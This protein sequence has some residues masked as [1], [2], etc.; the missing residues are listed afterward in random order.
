[1]SASI[2]NPR[3]PSAIHRKLHAVRL[4][5]ATLTV[6]AAVAL[7]GC[8][9]ITLM[10][11]SMAVDWLFPF[12]G[13]FLRVFLVAFTGLA[14]VGGAIGFGLKPLRSAL[15]WNDAAGAVDRAI[16]QLQ[17]RWSTVA[18]L[19]SHR[20]WTKTPL[21]R[22][23]ADQV[24]SEAIAMETVV[25]LSRITPPIAV[26]PPLLALATSGL[27]LAAL[28]AAAP[29]HLSVLLKRFWNPTCTVT[30]TTLI[31]ETGDRM[32]P[33][34]ESID[35]V[36][37]T[38][39]VFRN[40][41]TL[42]V[43]DPT[44]DVRRVALRRS[45]Q[46]PDAFEHRMKVDE[47]LRYRVRA[48][49]GQTAW[50]RLD[51][52]DYP[53]FAEIRFS[54]SFPDYTKRDAV[55]RERIPR[56]VKVV[57]GSVLGLA[58]KPTIPLKHCQVSLNDPDV[59]SGSKT[60]AARDSP[61]VDHPLKPDTDGWYRYRLPLSEDIILTASLISEHDLANRR[62]LFSRIDV[63][64]DKAPVARIVSPEDE[65]AVTLEEHI[66]IQFEA[67]DD[68]GIAT[69]ELVVFDESQKDET[70]QPKLVAV[71]P[72]ELGDQRFAKHVMGKAGLDLQRLGLNEGS[73]IS[74]AIR[75]TDNRDLPASETVRVA[76]TASND[77]DSKAENRTPNRS[78]GKTQDVTSRFA[79][80]PSGSKSEVTEQP[81]KA[82]AKERPA[83]D[84]TNRQPPNN[85]IGSG[86]PTNRQPEL[87]RSADATIEQRPTSRV[88]SSSKPSP[89]RPKNRPPVADRN[90][91]ANQVDLKAQRSRSGQD[92]QTGRRM[93]KI[94][95]KLAS[96]AE[97]KDRPGENQQIR[98]SV[99]EIDAML[100]EVETGLQKLVDHRVADSQRGEQLRRQDTALGGIES[101]IADLREQ[102]KENQFA[103]IG[104]QMLDIARTH[105]TPA[106][107][108][109]FAAMSRPNASDVDVSAS[110][111]HITRA[112]E[113]LAALLKRYDRVRQ[114]RKLADGMKE[115][116]KLYEVYLKKRRLLMREARQNR[117][118]LDR[119]LGIVEVDQAYLDRLAEV[120]QL[121]R[122]MIDEFARM[123]GDDPRL[124]SRYMELIQRRRDSLRDQLSEISQRQYDATE[125]LLGWL[126][127]DKT[128]Q[129]DYWN[130]IAELRIESATG[131]AKDA[132][133][134]AERV[135]KQMPLE[136]NK[137]AGV[138]AAVIKTANHIAADARSIDFHCKGLFDDNAVSMTPA[139]M[140]PTQSLLGQ[141]ERMF[142]LLDRLQFEN[143]NK[144]E[145]SDYVARR[146]LEARNV[147]DQADAWMS[148]CESLGDSDY[149][150]IVFTEQHRLGVTT[151]LLRVEMLALEDDLRA[152][153]R[154]VADE[155]VELSQ[156]IRDMLRRLHQLMESIT[157]N[158][159][160][161]AYRASKG[162]LGAA[163]GQQQ[164]AL[165]RLEQAEKLFDQL[166]RE[167]VD[168]LDRYDVRDPNIADLRDPTLDEFLARLERE[169][170]IVA[171]LGIPIRR[172]NLRVISD[173]LLWS[174]NG[175]GGMDGAEQAA[176]R[177]AQ[178]AMKMKRKSAAGSNKAKELS[179]QERERTQKAQQQLEEAL[180]KIEQQSDD[181]Q[182]SPK[183][184]ER[185][186]DA[187]ER[188][189]RMLEEPPDG[190]ADR[191]V[192]Q[193][194]VESDEA[195]ALIQIIA[196][197]EKIPDQQWNKLISTL[198]D[199][200]W[201]VR[202]N[203]APE[204]YR[205]AIEQYQDQIRE[206]MQTIDEE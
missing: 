92:T 179:E 164:L 154:R 30:A 129:P 13:D 163:S 172:T 16:P 183:D 103:F 176:A 194:I 182:T 168:Q 121:R 28:F 122:E 175:Q 161:A 50:H 195:E 25:Q 130:I 69:A 64:H 140:E 114:E 178:E 188:L 36:T 73:E 37:R 58:F 31:S 102:T 180:R 5:N 80:S 160:A 157:F 117:N 77:G 197:G 201:Q 60:D 133:E 12:S 41:A 26:R 119:K 91:P 65:T 142:A 181:P 74:Y 191:L 63:V 94:T 10:I 115:S 7:G 204:A 43:A 192:W 184:R 171:Q 88:T 55:L 167:V 150:R 144:A 75:V 104:L 177:R 20:N 21:Q 173:S 125:E 148:L 18:S 32:V 124:L 123:L 2:S 19:A 72:I 98:D 83:D 105:I 106:R 29:E 53:E 90:V 202:G 127:V 187:A 33:R 9:L 95:E 149:S 205:K 200:L 101:Y 56:R 185:L 11:V 51:V 86:D 59:E 199:G 89:D 35:L 23:M 111:Q 42:Y 156:T 54:I 87:M 97:A 84:T 147:A 110:L 1:M 166:R 141:C 113:L 132:A 128:Q 155:E 48:G 138:A 203:R 61:A 6:V 189:R 49:D 34:G 93:L 22:A 96:V 145:V 118:P 109:V 108:R 62:P 100:A 139:V 82:T 78:T 146:I 120:Q 174:E 134:L 68:F 52:I 107:D 14:A 46:D 8:L 3:L 186:K 169:P 79:S 116:V 196:R 47:S 44:G 66:E 81:R 39:G 15:G 67:H 206:L 70:G 136:L 135:E 152:Q 85:A 76:E 24:I 162:N 193:R 126:Q 151:Q 198:D 165:R 153:L 137:Q 131:L 112:R 27:V 45:E 57:Q 17:E 99:V 40:T 143:E 159:A 158:Q 38:R 170:N 4:R 190:D 71:K